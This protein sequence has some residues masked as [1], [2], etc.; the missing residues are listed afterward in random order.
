MWLKNTNLFF[1]P[2]PPTSHNMES[3]GIIMGYVSCSDGYISCSGSYASCSDGYVS[4]SDTE[5]LILFLGQCFTSAPPPQETHCIMLAWQAL[6]WISLLVG[7]PRCNPQENGTHPIS[8]FFLVTAQRNQEDHNNQLSPSLIT[9][10]TILS[11]QCQ[12][13]EPQRSSANLW[14]TQ[15][16]PLSGM[17]LTFRD[18]IYAHFFFFGQGLQAVI[19]SRVENSSLPVLHTMHER[20]QQADKSLNLSE[21]WGKSYNQNKNKL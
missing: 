9:T 12:R 14:K 4:Y 1:T 15:C 7:L 11:P 5:A 21:I 16:G 8:F 3:R 17:N 20:H 2:P 6:A 13:G 19:L 10:G 18:T